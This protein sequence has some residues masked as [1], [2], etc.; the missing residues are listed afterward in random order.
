MHYS[1]QGASRVNTALR[2]VCPVKPTTPVF[3]HTDSL[4]P[5]KSLNIPQR[6]ERLGFT[7]ILQFYLPNAS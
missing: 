4:L 1:V 5:L 6:R 2:G 7:S 3:I